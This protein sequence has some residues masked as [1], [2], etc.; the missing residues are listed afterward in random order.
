VFALRDLITPAER[1]RDVS[2][3]VFQSPIPMGVLDPI[4][5]SFNPATF[6]DL[7]A[8]ANFANAT[9]LGRLMHAWDLLFHVIQPDLI[10]GEYAPLL[11]VA[12]YGRIPMIT[13]G[14]GYLLP[15]P[16]LKQ[17]PV[18]DYARQ[19]VMP[20]EKLLEIVQ[21]V[22]A[23]RG[24]PQAPTLPAAIGG[25]ASFVTAYS[26]TDPYARLRAAR[27]VGPLEA[28]RP[29]LPPAQPRYYAYLSA[30]YRPLRQL[31]DGIV[32]ANLPGSI[33]IKRITSQLRQFL[34]ERDIDVLDAP[35][36]LDQAV[37]NASFVIHHGGMATTTAALG[38]G[39]PQMLWSQVT[40]QAVTANAINQLGVADVTGARYAN[41][42]EAGKAMRRMATDQS[43]MARA[44]GL[45][46][47]LEADG[48]GN[49]LE[50][51]LAA[52]RTLLAARRV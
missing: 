24:L 7:L 37:A 1:L 13:M 47:R 20:Q 35:P 14:H 10:I 36:P 27:A 48:E 38:M 52:A 21:H 23:E 39:R 41:G 11:A 2:W 9:E 31:L 45:A 49:S 8:M 18:F 28:Y 50:K 32:G 26:V 43:M 22:Q 29:I 42:G 3:P 17:F 30:D 15:P 25:N 19:P 44:Q 33:Y 12:A 34:V 6:A 40:D 46:A 51:I 5:P 16:E 4:L